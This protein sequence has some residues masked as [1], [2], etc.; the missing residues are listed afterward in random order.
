MWTWD[1]LSREV[2]DY[3]TKKQKC[4]QWYTIPRTKKH[5]A[6]IFWT[7]VYRMSNIIDLLKHQ[8]AIEKVSTPYFYYGGMTITVRNQTW[9][10]VVTELLEA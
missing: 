3:M 10:T 7:S 1:G 2:R 8:G 9:Y 5:L 4:V 6:K